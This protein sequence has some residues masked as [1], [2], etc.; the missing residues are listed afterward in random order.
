MLIVL[1]PD[2]TPAQY[3]AVR[4]FVTRHGGA[5][6]PVDQPWPGL[7][8]T[9][10]PGPLPTDRIARMEGVADVLSDGTAPRLVRA[11]PGAPRTVVEVRGAQIGSRTPAIIAGPC[12]V[13]S[14]EQVLRV[15]QTLADCGVTWFRGGA[16]KPRTSPYSFQG[17]REEGLHL[18]RE[19]KARFDLRIVTEVKDLETLPAVAA[20]ADV[21]QIGSRNMYN[22]SLLEAVGRSSHPVL[23]K[24]GMSAT[25]QEWLASAEYVL[26][27]GN[28]NVILCERGIRTFETA[29]RNTLDL[30][31]A[32]VARGLTHLPVIADPSH[33]IGVASGV[34]AMALAA[35]AAGL[36][37]ILIEVHPSPSEALS[38]G[39]QAIEPE[40]FVRLVDQIR[41]VAEAIA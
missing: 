4:D 25:I 2:A 10:L 32:V 29:T 38:D 11:N 5:T 1:K 33:G 28:R 15:A 41:A 31:G 37:G 30:G 3:D 40:R 19:V 7:T 34:P 35:I 20:V 6:H 12:A 9:G 26:A 22:Y 8:V 18:L 36:D 21:L 23:L 13:E 16:F 39:H 24:R 14:R 17:L 27:G